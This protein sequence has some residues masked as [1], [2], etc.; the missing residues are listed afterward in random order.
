MSYI[1]SNAMTLNLNHLFRRLDKNKRVNECSA[2]A[3]CSI[4]SPHG[5]GIACTNSIDKCRSYRLVIRQ[6]WLDHTTDRFLQS[7]FKCDVPVPTRESI[8]AV[9]VP[10]VTGRSS[11]SDLRWYTVPHYR[12]SMRY[13]LPSRRSE[14]RSIGEMERTPELNTTCHLCQ[15]HPDIN[16]ARLAITVDGSLNPP[17]TSR[18]NQIMI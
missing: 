18:F 10:S 11:S 13:S 3:A 5:K 17:I 15:T 6:Q 9:D 1:I 7:Q 12:R 2:C 14:F 8:H 16:V 4:A